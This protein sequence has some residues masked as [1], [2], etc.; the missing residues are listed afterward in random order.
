MAA[1][2]CSSFPGEDSG[3]QVRGLV[4][5]LS[6]TRVTTVSIEP[7]S[8]S[9]SRPG[10]TSSSNFLSAASD[11]EQLRFLDLKSKIQVCIKRSP[12]WGAKKNQTRFLK[13]CE[14]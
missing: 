4:R 13:D 2:V 8:S 14:S 3:I 12:I 7:H 9:R 5:R 11:L 10:E 6:S 1:F